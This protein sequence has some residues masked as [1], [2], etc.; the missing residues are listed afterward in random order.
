MKKK[1]KAF[2]SFYKFSCKFY[3]NFS[4]ESIAQK[5]Y[6]KFRTSSYFDPADTSPNDAVTRGMDESVAAAA[7]NMPATPVTNIGQATTPGTT[8]RGRM[9]SIGSTV[10]S[11]CSAAEQFSKSIKK[12]MKD[13]E[14]FKHEK[15][16]DN[17]NRIFKTMVTNHDCE[18][19]I[20]KNYLRP[21]QHRDPK[22]SN[23]LLRRINIFMKYF[24]KP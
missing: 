22:N 17:W 23:Y 14:E 11:T 19:M 24:R 20:D 21:S 15:D 16:W 4:I 9:S 10:T 7:A 18:E 5:H 1:F 3:N 13:F 12:D 6:D 2:L 8:G